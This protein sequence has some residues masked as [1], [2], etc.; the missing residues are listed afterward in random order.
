MTEGQR[1]GGTEHKPSQAADSF[2]QPAIFSIFHG[3][4]QLGMLS[5]NN[6]QSRLQREQYTAEQE[7]IEGIS[8]EIIMP[9]QHVKRAMMTRQLIDVGR[10][11]TDYS[12]QGRGQVDQGEAGLQQPQDVAFFNQGHEQTSRQQS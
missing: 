7:Q 1:P 9:L 2:E 4:A 12:G 10:N 6:D 5:E 3:F 8:D 11:K